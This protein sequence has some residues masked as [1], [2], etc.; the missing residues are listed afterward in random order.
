SDEEDRSPSSD[1]EN[2]SADE[3]SFSADLDACRDALVEEYMFV[4]SNRY[5]SP[6]QPVLRTGALVD[7][8]FEN[9][10]H[11]PSAFR[12]TVRVS[13]PAFDFILDAIKGDDVFRSAPGK[14]QTK[15]DVQLAVF[16]YRLGHYGN[17]V[18]ESS[19]ASYF[20]LGKGTVVKCTNRTMQA[21]LRADKIKKSVRWP[22]EGQPREASKKEAAARSILEWRG[23]WCGVDGTTV[24]LSEKPYLYG[25]AWF[26]R[27][28]RYSMNV[29]IVNGHQMNII[30]F[31]V[32]RTGSRCDSVAFEDTR[33]AQHHKDML[34]DG[35]W[36]WGDAGYKRQ[37][38]LEDVQYACSWLRAAVLLHQTAKWVEQGKA[39]EDPFY[40]DGTAWEAAEREEEA[41]SRGGEG[42]GGAAGATG[43]AAGE[44]RAAQLVRAHKFRDGLME[45]LCK[46]KPPRQSRRTF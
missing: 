28:G 41:E 8:L 15:V 25:P 24:P 16:L 39:S 5:L 10:I 6:R 26:D 23:G 36:C 35:E 2:L 13:G 44:S 21:V 7:I 32:G 18:K 34:G 19:V 37:D 43:G 46:A 30:D 42:D 45:I 11:R 12:E 20:G 17:G 9:K 22:A 3:D 38:W 31:S 1:E 4:A 29:Q 27:K 40:M 33:L 14:T